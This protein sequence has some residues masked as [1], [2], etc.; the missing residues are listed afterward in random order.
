[1]KKIILWAQ[2]AD[3]CGIV[4]G[5]TG[6]LLEHGFNLED[7]SMTILEGHFA[8]ILIASRQGRFTLKELMHAL[9]PVKKK[10]GM[11]ISVK[12]FS[13]ATAKKMSKKTAQPQPAIVTVF[14]MD[15]P[16]IVHYVAKYLAS[17]KVNITDV[18]SHVTGQKDAPIYVMALDVELPPALKDK[19]FKA[20]LDKIGKKLDADIGL[21]LIGTGVL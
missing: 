8:M 9:A 7:T 18:S 13:V 15:K 1:M 11:D 6:V 19:E 16:G 17:K 14:G 5:V 3:R 12:F 2:G 21:S 10:L 4:S 20:G